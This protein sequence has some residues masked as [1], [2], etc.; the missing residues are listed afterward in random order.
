M[1][2]EK[3]TSLFVEA[4]QHTEVDVRWITLEISVSVVRADKD[5]AIGDRGV[6]EGLGTERDGPLDIL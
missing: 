5:T 6:T 2:P 4:Q 1:L 3:P